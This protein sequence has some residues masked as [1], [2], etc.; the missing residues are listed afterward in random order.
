MTIQCSASD[1]LQLR[2][3]LE[4][5]AVL[6]LIARNDALVYEALVYAFVHDS[7][8]ALQLH[9][10]LALAHNDLHALCKVL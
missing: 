2:I 8:R 10:G 9:T 7:V 3:Q 1:A 4:L 6:A 5:I